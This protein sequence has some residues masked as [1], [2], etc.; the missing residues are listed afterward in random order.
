[1]AHAIQEY[2]GQIVIAGI[3]MI[4]MLTLSHYIGYLFR[5]KTMA[6]NPNNP[7]GVIKCVEAL[8]NKFDLSM[9]KH[10]QRSEKRHDKVVE[11]LEDIKIAI[12]RLNSGKS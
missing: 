11:K 5:K 7:N 8:E 10:D 2:V 12:V 9:D 3:G 1:M 6:K 4:A